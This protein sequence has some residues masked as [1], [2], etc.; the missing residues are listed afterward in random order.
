VWYWFT[1]PLLAGFVW[2]L[3]M[4]VLSEDAV[5]LVHLAFFADHHLL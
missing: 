4:L 2:A 3:L 5:A 1:L